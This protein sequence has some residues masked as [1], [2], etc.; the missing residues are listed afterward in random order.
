MAIG[1]TICTPYVQ[2][3]R[4]DVEMLKAEKERAIIAKQEAET[5]LK[6]TKK[7]IEA[8]ELV[9]HLL[10]YAGLSILHLFHLEYDTATEESIQCGRGT[11]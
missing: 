8:Q 10:L 11:E 1:Y 2:D 7:A 6:N 3:A 4:R 5:A 9:G